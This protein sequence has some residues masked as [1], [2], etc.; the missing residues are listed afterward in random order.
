MRKPSFVKFHINKIYQINKYKLNTYNNFY[1]YSFK[2]YNIDQ[3]DLARFITDIYFEKGLFLNG[4]KFIECFVNLKL[5]TSSTKY[6]ISAI[7]FYRTQQ[8]TLQLRVLNSICIS[9]LRPIAQK[10]LETK[11][12]NK[13]KVWTNTTKITIETV[14]TNK[15]FNVC[16][17]PELTRINKLNLKKDKIK[18]NCNFQTL[19]FT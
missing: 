10:E 9:L 11:K 5:L 13:S 14:F 6:K 16:I 18:I 3:I 8:N 2:I 19:I 4:I 12:K 1:W 7:T 15:L 17:L